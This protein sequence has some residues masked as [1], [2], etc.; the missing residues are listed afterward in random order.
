MWPVQLTDSLGV[1]HTSFPNPLSSDSDQPRESIE[2]RT[3][4]YYDEREGRSGSHRDG[5]G[6]ELTR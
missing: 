6:I 4:V 3:I 1:P 2:V 5:D